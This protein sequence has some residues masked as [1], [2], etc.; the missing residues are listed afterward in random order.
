MRNVYPN[1]VV[2][3]CNRIRGL[4]SIVIVRANGLFIEYKAVSLEFICLKSAIAS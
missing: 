1:K 2:S 4:L 3:L